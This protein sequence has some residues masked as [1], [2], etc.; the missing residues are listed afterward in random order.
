MQ[1]HFLDFILPPLAC[2]VPLITTPGIGAHELN[3]FPGI[4]NHQVGGPS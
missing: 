2:G 3:L 1:V 4:D